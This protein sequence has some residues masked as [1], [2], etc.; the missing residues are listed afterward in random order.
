MKLQGLLFVKCLVKGGQHTR[1][2]NKEFELVD[3]IVLSSISLLIFCKFT[4]SITEK[5][6]VEVSCSYFEFVLLLSV[7]CFMFCKLCFRVLTHLGLLPLLDKLFV[8]TECPFLALVIISLQSLPGINT[9]TL[10]L[11]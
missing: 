8:I 3:S 6:V 9:T 7:I 5:G 2:L 11:L 1:H 4:V 10:V